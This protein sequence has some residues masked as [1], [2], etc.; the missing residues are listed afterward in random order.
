MSLTFS[1][2]EQHWKIMLTEGVDLVLWINGVP[3]RIPWSVL[4]VF[5]PIYSLTGGARPCN[6][7]G[8]PVLPQDLLYW[9][10]KR[11][12]VWTCLCP[13]DNKHGRA[14]AMFFHD[15][16]RGNVWV[17]CGIPG[18]GCGLR[19]K[20]NILQTVHCTNHIQLTYPAFTP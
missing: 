11:H 16:D 18:G 19:R 3:C 20:A 14:L 13:S 12:L 7:N 2:R 10:R 9:L 6:E 1:S 4:L 15:T 17:E 8:H 5:L